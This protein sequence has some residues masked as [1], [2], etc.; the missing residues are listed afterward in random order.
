MT[1]FELPVVLVMH[2]AKSKL[3]GNLVCKYYHR[4]QSVI[5]NTTFL[6]IVCLLDV[7]AIG[8][9]RSGYLRGNTMWLGSY[10]ECRDISGAQYCTANLT[11]S[12]KK[13]LIPVC[14]IGIFF[15]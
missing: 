1:I 7:D 5:L 4:C 10:S 2:Y 11:I 15:A 12:V 3:A 8:K 9:P 14:N 6:K 13:S